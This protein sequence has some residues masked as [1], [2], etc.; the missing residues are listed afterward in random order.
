MTI[1]GEA[2]IHSLEIYKYEISFGTRK[3]IVLGILRTKPTYQT[4]IALRFVYFQ[5]RIHW[6][7]GGPPAIC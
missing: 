5:F 1:A 2:R 7:G 4:I 3:H 6:R